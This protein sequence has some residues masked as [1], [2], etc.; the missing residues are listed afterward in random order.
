M[1]APLF[2]EREVNQI[3]VHVLA[4]DKYKTNTIVV[5]IQRPLS[6][7][8]VT[9]TALMP[10][11]LR[12]G[13]ATYPTFKEIKEH[14]DDLYGATFYGN[15]MKRGERHILQFGLEIANERYL[16]DSTPL[17]DKGMAFLGELLTR[18]ALEGRG[19]VDQYVRSEKQNLKQRIEGLINDKMRYAAER[20]I[21]EMCHDEPYRL[22]HYGRVED[23]KKIDRESLYDS[24]Q[25]VLRHAPMDVFVVG[26]VKE[27]EVIAAVRRYFGFE[28]QGVRPVEVSPVERQVDEVK[29][30]ID[31]L[32]VQQGKLNLG[33]RTNT[34]I[35]DDDYIPLMVY[36]GILGGF[37]HSKLFLN[38][39]EKASLAYYAASRL[40]S[41]KGLMTIQSGIEIGHFDQALDIIQK[42]LD[43]M[44]AGQITDR[45][46][47]QTQTMLA[48]QLREMQDRPHQLIDF[49][50]H[51]ILSGKRR[52]L[53]DFLTQLFTTTIQDV[54]RVARKIHLDTIY[55]LR[56]RQEA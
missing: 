4:T 1:K 10:P 35:A 33:L 56:D 38:V 24:F 21:Q 30:I 45:E 8:E 32:D 42:Q 51:G 47:T 53:D 48:N 25:D 41:H 52:S 19:F 20:C 6:E 18:P 2:Q 5:N 22:F 26:D 31:R 55:F 29:R 44:Q 54:K 37:P 36:N 34:S 27:D 14:L 11:V 28:R 17:M 9:T 3:H 40:E 13:T 7:M 46:M 43:E 16:S 12:R 39:R 15:V 49:Y 23:L 50:Y